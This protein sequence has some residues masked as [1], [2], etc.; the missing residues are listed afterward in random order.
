MAIYAIIE[1]GIVV[2]RIEADMPEYLTIIFEKEV[3]YVKETPE[4]GVAYISKRYS[5]EKNKFEPIQI[6]SSWIWDEN[7]FDYVPPIERPNGAFIWNEE[8]QSWVELSP[9]IVTE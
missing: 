4:T 3:Y 5:E 9:E 8:T 2:N 1:D 7:L 6:F